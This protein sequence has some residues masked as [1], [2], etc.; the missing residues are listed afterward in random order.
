MSQ[1]HPRVEAVNLGNFIGD[2]QDLSTIRGGSLLLLTP[3][4]KFRVTF[5]STL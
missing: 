2:T 5:L 4:M 1:Y 3:Q